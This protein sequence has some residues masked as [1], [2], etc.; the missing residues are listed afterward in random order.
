M[1]YVRNIADHGHRPDDGRR[2]HTDVDHRHRMDADPEHR[3]ADDERR[4]R[5][6]RGDGFRDIGRQLGDGHPP[7]GG[8]QGDVPAHDDDRGQH[9][10]PKH[11]RRRRGTS[12]IPRY[13]VNLGRI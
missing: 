1:R 7:R 2:R 6:G 3:R 13:I 9:H 10:R 12:R 5:G 4:R 8:R 11:R